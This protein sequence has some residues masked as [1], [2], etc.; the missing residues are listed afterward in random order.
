MT[1][2]KK[3]IA[4]KKPRHVDSVVRDDNEEEEVTS[5][6]VR[7]D[8]DAE[9][10]P[11][12]TGMTVAAAS[13]VPMVSSPAEVSKTARDLI[14]Q[15][16]TALSKRTETTYGPSSVALTL[17]N[18]L[19]LDAAMLLEHQGRGRLF[20]DDKDEWVFEFNEETGAGGIL[21]GDILQNKD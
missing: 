19:E 15:A 5:M 17:E 4:D 14:L 18:D 2:K 6:V 12:E 3:K 20:K 1:K 7:E 11:K 16:K 21:K 13:A 8:D 9:P 10:A